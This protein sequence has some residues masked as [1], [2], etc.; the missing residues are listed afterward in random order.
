MCYNITY[1]DIAL[2]P[3]PLSSPT[4]LRGTEDSGGGG[5]GGSCADR[6]ASVLSAKTC[7]TFIKDKTINVFIKKKQ[8]VPNAATKRRGIHG[9]LSLHS[10]CSSRTPAFPRW[11]RG[12]HVSPNAPLAPPPIAPRYHP[13]RKHT[14][15]GARVGAQIIHEYVQTTYNHNRI[16]YCSCVDC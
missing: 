11:Q 6:N 9:F 13:F 15:H 7:L 8:H 10:S 12:N 5:G 1:I 3:F 4:I 14:S 16:K 2:A